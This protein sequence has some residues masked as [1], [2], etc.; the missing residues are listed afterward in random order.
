MNIMQSIKKKKF[1][2]ASAIV[3]LAI[4][5]STLALP[6]PAYA[7]TFANDESARFLSR[8]E[9][10][11]SEAHLA[12][13]NLQHNNIR[14]AHE[15]ANNAIRLL[16]NG[17][18]LSEIRERNDRIATSLQNILHQLHNSI[19]ASQNVGAAN[20]NQAI[21]T[22]DQTVVA[23]NNT[24]GE[25]TT[26]RIEPNQRDNSTVWALA[27]VGVLNA[28]LKDY[29]NATGA[30]FDLTNMANMGS[31][32]STTLGNSSG[33]NKMSNN[34]SNTSG[35][36]KGA[37]SNATN[38]VNQTSYQSA[39][40]LANKTL[41]DLFNSRLK[42]AADNSTTTANTASSTQSSAV[43]AI[44]QL[45]NSILDLKNAINNKAHPEQVMMIVHGKIHPLLIQIFRL[46]G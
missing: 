17:T 44:G 8:T 19:L 20:P 12:L 1:Y 27:F 14:L 23:L 16:E 15:H 18:T 42:L 28:T 39:Q 43:P 34:N 21:Q 13:I 22:V 46:Q 29:G 24:L 35:M 25:A 31:R 6:N 33:N 37:M 9:L 10:I 41:I 45:Q 26:V 40:F 5:M 3:A 36:I 11:R 32:M 38:I 7:H 4:L 2:A 30:P